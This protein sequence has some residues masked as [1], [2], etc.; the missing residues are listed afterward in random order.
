MA[1]RYTFAGPFLDR[2]THLRTEPAWFD[3]ANADP[4][5]RAV[6]QWNARSLVLDGDPPRAALVALSD[7]PAEGRA[8]ENL[9]LLGHFAGR[10]C[11]AAEIDALEPPQIVPGARFEDLRAVL[12]RLA[13]EDAGLLGYARALL[14]WRARHRYCGACG[15][16]TLPAR[17]GHTRVCSAPACRLEHF[18]R[19]DPAIIVLVS[20]GARALLGRQPSWPPG[21]F[22]TIAGFVEPGEALEDAVAREVQEETGVEVDQ[23]TYFG[24]QPW[25]F[26]GSLMLG[27]TARAVSTTIRLNDRELE[28][29]RW[30]TR[31]DVAAGAVRLPLAQSI[32]YALIE[33]WFD[34]GGTSLATLPGAEP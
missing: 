16:P 27:F 13:A 21:R 32:S 9:I 19:I 26:P 1:R 2:V 8:P 17:A 6:V 15:A 12:P 11:F 33:A 3:A 7:L 28:D 31:A 10:P 23:I 24:S 5:G 20:D 22:S 34:A 25:P 30:F 18:P 14:A 29:A 4:D